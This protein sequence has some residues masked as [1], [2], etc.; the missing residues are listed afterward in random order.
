MFCWQAPESPV[1]KFISRFG[2][3]PPCGLYQENELSGRWSTE[4]LCESTLHMEDTWSYIT[5]FIRHNERGLCQDILFIFLT[6]A[7]S[8]PLFSSPSLSVCIVRTWRC[9]LILLHDSWNGL[10]RRRENNGLAV[11]VVCSYL[12]LWW[13]LLLSPASA[14][15]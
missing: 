9:L 3:F 7:L 6:L 12:C 1:H 2:V 5:A 10:T 11:V 13:S 8:L 14:G 4:T 15:L